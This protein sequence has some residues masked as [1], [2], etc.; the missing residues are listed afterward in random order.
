MTTSLDQFKNWVI[1]ETGDVIVTLEAKEAAVIAFFKPLITQVVT[2]AEALG[3]TDFDAGLKVLTD[4]AEAGV[5]A[6]LPI[7]ATGNIQ[8]AETAA[9]AAFLATGASE[10]VTAVSNASAGLIKAA[11]AIEQSAASE[12]AAVSTPPAVAP[13][14]SSVD[15]SSV[16]QNPAES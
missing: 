12:L 3:K 14:D 11:V 1:S 7:I 5:Q 16:V 4:S 8:G 15:P 13:V 10:G 2:E 6:G 9:A